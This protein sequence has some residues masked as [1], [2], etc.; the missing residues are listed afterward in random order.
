MEVGQTLSHFVGSLKKMSG[1]EEKRREETKQ[2]KGMKRKQVSASEKGRVC[3][4]RRVLS[5]S[6]FLRLLLLLLFLSLSINVE[7]SQR[8]TRRENYERGKR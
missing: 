1:R 4:D 8:N 2:D 3:E 6:S 7:Q 5:A